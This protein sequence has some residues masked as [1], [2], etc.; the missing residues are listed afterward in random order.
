[1]IKKITKKNNTKNERKNKMTTL[2]KN[3]SNLLGD[4]SIDQ[5]LNFNK[6]NSI[7]KDYLEKL[8]NETK[9]PKILVIIPMNSHADS[10]KIKYF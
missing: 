1:M 8:M 6:S 4:F 10:N 5:L 7:S 3:K 9:S 2:S